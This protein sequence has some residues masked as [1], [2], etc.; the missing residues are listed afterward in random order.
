MFIQYS[1]L[2]LYR[3]IQV[4]MIGDTGPVFTVYTIILM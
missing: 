1:H 4:E 3:F 2:K